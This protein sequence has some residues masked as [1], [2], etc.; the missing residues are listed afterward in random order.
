MKEELYYLVPKEQ[1]D[2]ISRQ[3]EV[4]SETNNCGLT[5]DKAKEMLSFKLIDLS[6]EAIEERAEDYV[7][8]YY[9]RDMKSFYNV[10]EILTIKHYSK[11][12]KDLK[13]K[14]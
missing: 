8:N 14:L 3:L 12:L 11:A 9:N 13:Q 2:L 1:L 4:L 7:N 5:N 10:E 6:D